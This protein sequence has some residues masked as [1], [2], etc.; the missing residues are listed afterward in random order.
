MRRY[1]VMKAPLITLAACLV[2]MVAGFSLCMPGPCGCSTLAQFE[3]PAWI[4]TGLIYMMIAGFCGAPV[5]LLWLLVAAI[6]K[7]VRRSRA[8]RSASAAS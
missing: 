3:S 6:V 2:V 8:H 5:S 7:L 1:G 4:E